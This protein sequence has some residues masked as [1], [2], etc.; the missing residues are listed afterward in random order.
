[1]AIP[2]TTE[3]ARFAVRSL[4]AADSAVGDHQLVLDICNLAIAVLGSDTDRATIATARDTEVTRRKNLGQK[5][6]YGGA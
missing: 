3:Q 1:M 4:L 2:I 5:G 6:L